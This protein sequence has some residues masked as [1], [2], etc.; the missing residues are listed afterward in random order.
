MVSRMIE[1]LPSSTSDKALSD[2]SLMTRLADVDRLEGHLGA[3]EVALLYIEAEG[4][5]YV[6]TSHNNQRTPLHNA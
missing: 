6:R 1:C 5:S 2:V 3:C 4:G